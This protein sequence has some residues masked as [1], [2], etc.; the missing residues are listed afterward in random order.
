MKENREFKMSCYLCKRHEPSM[1]ADGVHCRAK[2]FEIDHERAVSIRCEMF[3][4]MA[5]SE[6]RYWWVWNK[7]KYSKGIYASKDGTPDK[8]ASPYQLEI[9]QPS[10]PEKPVEPDWPNGWYWVKDEN[11]RELFRRKSGY[12]AYDKYNGRREEWDCYEVVASFNG[13]KFVNEEDDR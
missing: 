8:Q 3:E 11:G 4:R 6:W 13:V 9:E 1:G 2:G 12:H 7:D 10:C 5:A